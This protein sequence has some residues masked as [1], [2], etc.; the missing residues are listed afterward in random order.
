MRDRLG[1]TGGSAGGRSVRL[2][3]ELRRADDGNPKAAPTPS[4]AA[5]PARVARGR[6]PPSARPIS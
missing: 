2:M 4:S 1:I 6:L 3:Q 5:D